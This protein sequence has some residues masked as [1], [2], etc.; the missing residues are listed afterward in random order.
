MKKGAMVP[1][2]A[3]SG[4][5]FLVGWYCFARYPWA[6]LRRWV[7]LFLLTIWAKVLP[8]STFGAFVSEYFS[9][10]HL[11]RCFDGLSA[12]PWHY[13]LQAAPLLVAEAFQTKAIVAWPGYCRLKTLNAALPFSP[14]A[15]WQSFV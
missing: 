7:A 10:L 4:K 9:N 8:G 2:L 15:C 5:P 14:R 11:A 1:V 12:R 13:A 3:R 6:G